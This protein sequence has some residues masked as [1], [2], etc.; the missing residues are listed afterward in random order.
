LSLVNSGSLN[1]ENALGLIF[2]ANI[3]TTITAQIVAFKLTNFSLLIFVA[4]FLISMIPTKEFI[5]E[6]GRG[7]MGIGFIFVGMQF[8][9]QSVSPL[10]DSTFL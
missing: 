6:I 1:F 3:G 10:K 7:I 4:G 2:G 9:E 5:R 8:M